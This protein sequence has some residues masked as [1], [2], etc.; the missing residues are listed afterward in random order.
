MNRKARSSPATAMEARGDNLAVAGKDLHKLNHYRKNG[1]YPHNISLP[2]T[3]RRLPPR[4]SCSNPGAEKG[5]MTDV[6]WKTSDPVRFRR[7][8]SAPCTMKET[9]PT[10]SVFLSVS[11]QQEAGGFHRR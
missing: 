7:E 9:P 2:R 4:S 8:K 10:S 11:V 1:P 3:W 5:N 6:I